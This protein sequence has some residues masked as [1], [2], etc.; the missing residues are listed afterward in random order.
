MDLRILQW[1]VEN[2]SLI[3][4]TLFK[5]IQFNIIKKLTQKKNLSANENR[6]LRGA[7]K[8]KLTIIEAIT[9]IKHPKN[10]LA[11]FLNKIDSY[12]IT[13]SGALKHNGYGWFFEPKIIEIINTKIS[14][15]VKINKQLVK[16]FRVKSIIKSKIT[17]DKET[18]I[19]YALNEQIIKDTKITKNL[20]IKK[21]WIQM[22]KRYGN[23]FV[24]KEFKE[25]TEEKINYS[26]YGV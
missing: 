10:D 7:I 8:N 24:E 13:G 17:I 12:H 5:P 21:L 4:P 18:G 14:G 16:F 9:K 25:Y 26:E 2:E 3:V 11:S 23:L 15:Q 6:Y 19:K 22:Y 1:I 20:Y